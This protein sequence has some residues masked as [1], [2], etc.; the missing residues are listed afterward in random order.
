MNIALYGLGGLPGVAYRKAHENEL[1]C[2]LCGKHRG[3][4][5]GPLELAAALGPG[6]VP[7][8]PDQAIRK[9]EQMETLAQGRGFGLKALAAI[10]GVG[11]AAVLLFSIFFFDAAVLTALGVLSSLIGGLTSLGLF[12]AA[13]GL[14]KAALN[15]AE[16]TRLRALADLAKR[17][18]GVLT[19][20]QAAKALRLPASKVEP[21]LTAVVDHDR[22]E[23]DVD[24]D[25]TLTYR[26]LDWM[27]PKELPPGDDPKA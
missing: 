5:S 8:A 22:I 21:L 18:H 11:S 25:G 4:V 27:P 16:M 10:F 12:V 23:M 24:G 14:R 7:V 13:R 9:A 2:E 6:G 1:V 3:F 17:H 20:D 15:D 26:F 19:L